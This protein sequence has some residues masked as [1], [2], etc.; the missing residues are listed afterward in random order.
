M[1]AK[2]FRQSLFQGKVLCS[3]DKP[4]ELFLLPQVIDR[5]IS[6]LHLKNNTEILVELNSAL[7]DDFGINVHPHISTITYITGG[8]APTIV[9]EV[10]GE[11]RSPRPEALP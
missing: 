10:W 11:A 1:T 2:E 3:E 4:R 8:G 9:L 6:Q 7:V 5:R